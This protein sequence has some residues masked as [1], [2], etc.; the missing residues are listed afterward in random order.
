M[1]QKRQSKFF[2]IL[3][4]I[5][6][7]GCISSTNK[8][9]VQAVV[10]VNGESLS[11]K[12]FAEGLTVKLRGRDAISVKNPANVRRAKEEVISSFVSSQLFRSWAKENSVV[13][14]DE[15]LEAEI[16]TIKKSYP[17]TIAFREILARENLD[18]GRWKETVRTSLL[19]KRVYAFLAKDITPPEQKDIESYFKSNQQEFSRKP[20]VHIRQLVVRK[21]EDAQSILKRAQQK[22]D[23]ADLAKEF[24]IMPEASKGGDIG[25]IEKGTL[26]V[27]DKA[28]S[29]T[30]GALSSV[31]KS[32][33]GF[34]ILQVIDRRPETQLKIEDVR[35]E[36]KRRL[37]ADREQALFTRWLEDQVK[38]ARVLRNEELIGSVTVETQ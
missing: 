34:H 14:S 38:A 6:F 17:D 2:C 33:Y 21:D 35:G 7:C 9:A 25:W 12:Q 16:A 26:E 31:I 11:A 1:P 5:L 13:V 15:E 27:F 29:M 28:F 18:Y 24:S 10:T 32:P 4:V 20:Q 3:G 23:L 8:I 19:E 37:M 36:I 22:K 30:K